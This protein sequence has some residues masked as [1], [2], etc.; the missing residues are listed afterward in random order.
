[1]EGEGAEAKIL[2][3]KSINLKIRERAGEIARGLSIKVIA[4]QTNSKT[5][6]SPP[7]ILA[8]VPHLAG[9]EFN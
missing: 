2:I 8:G 6:F 1:M 5:Y 9:K 4:I 3:F 7:V